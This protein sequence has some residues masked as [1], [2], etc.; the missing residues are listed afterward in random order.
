MIPGAG[1][2]LLHSSDPNK[3]QDVFDSKTMIMLWPAYVA[4]LHGG[5]CFLKFHVISIANNLQ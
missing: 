1:L 4:D 2:P 3:D 5:G